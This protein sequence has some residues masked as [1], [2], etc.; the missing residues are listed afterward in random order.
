[1]RIISGAHRGRRLTGPPEEGTRPM[2]DRVREAVFS[3][4]GPRFEGARVLDLFAGTGSLGLEAF[5]RGASH[6]RFLEQG[7]AAF[8]ILRSNIEA[9]GAEEQADPRRAD[10]LDPQALV[11]PAQGPWDV[12][13]LDPP[14]PLM[15]TD[16]GRISIL[17]L[18]ETALIEHSEDDA[19]AILHTPSKLLDERDWPTTLATAERTYGNNTAIWYAEVDR[20]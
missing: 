4:V 6:V 5:S 15:R 13:F 19:I 11:P 10:A 16:T 7:A 9:L 3:T 1:M 14:Y 18:V 8:E 17:T 20:D 2:L 12:L